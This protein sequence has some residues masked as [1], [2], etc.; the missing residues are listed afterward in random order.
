M[1]TDA[2]KAHFPKERYDEMMTSYAK[3]LTRFTFQT[4]PAED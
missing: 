3:A 1:L 2:Q 4:G